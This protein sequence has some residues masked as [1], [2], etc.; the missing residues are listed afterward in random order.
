MLT[1]NCCK[2]WK[3]F[4]KLFALLHP[5]CP[6][7]NI[8]SW[9]FG[10]YIIYEK[11]Y[12]ICIKNILR[13]IFILNNYILK[14][15]NNYCI[16]L[17]GSEV[18]HRIFL[19]CNDIYITFT[20]YSYYMKYKL[21]C[22]SLTKITLK[23]YS[24]V[25]WVY[26]IDTE[27]GFHIIK[28]YIYVLLNLYYF[29]NICTDQNLVPILVNSVTCRQ[30]QINSSTISHRWRYCH[31]PIINVNDHSLFIVY[32]FVYIYYNRYLC[33]DCKIFYI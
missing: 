17:R 28:Y 2:T 32:I 12:Y 25:T 29:W 18:V 14:L 10:C 27:Y 16:W 33:I 31:T 3:Y 20:L 1:N 11:I 6:E 13:T 24:I 15:H 5:V 7:P 22:I 23:I 8:P 30:Q 21:I 4:I 26:D 19:I 9:S